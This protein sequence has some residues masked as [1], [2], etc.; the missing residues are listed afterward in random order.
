MLCSQVSPQ[1]RVFEQEIGVD[2]ARLTRWRRAEPV[3]VGGARLIGQFVWGRQLAWSAD[4]FAEQSVLQVMSVY[5]DEETANSRP[6]SEQE[7]KVDDADQIAA[8]IGHAGPAFPSRRQWRNVAPGDDLNQGILQQGTA[9]GQ[10]F[11][12]LWLVAGH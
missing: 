9:F 4:P 7:P 6:E 1:P 12:Q 2:H 8:E 3:W 11:E 10:K 5:C